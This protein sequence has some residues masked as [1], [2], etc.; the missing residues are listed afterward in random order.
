MVGHGGSSASSYLADP[1][2][3]IPSHCAS[4]VATSTLRVNGHLVLDIS[5]TDM[6]ECKDIPADKMD[7][8]RYSEILLIYAYNAISPED[9]CTLVTYSTYALNLIPLKSL[10]H[11]VKEKGICL[12]CT[13]PCNCTCFSDFTSPGS[14]PLQLP[15]TA[16]EAKA[17]QYQFG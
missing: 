8:F 1:T 13:Y 9:Y 10:F 7:M 17:G 14:D 11:L 3:P 6:T 4:I 2:S 15:T 12:E 16:G 5:V